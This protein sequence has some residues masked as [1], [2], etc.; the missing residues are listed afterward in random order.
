MIA[1]M[2][3]AAALSG[4][5]LLASCNSASSPDAPAGT[6]AETAMI[7]VTRPWSRETAQGQDAGGAFLSISNTGQTADRLVGGSTPVAADVQV[8]TVDMA[9]G[10]MR[11]RQ[12]ED[13]LEIPAGQTV[14][15]KPGSFHI[16]LMQLKQPLR[17]GEK[18]PLTLQFENAGSIPVELD[19]Q[20]VGTA[21]PAEAA[22][23]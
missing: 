8:H 23:D 5:A 10:V 22:G 17:R 18:V 11:M 4:T 13:G 19:V 1:R 20:P 2:F 15:L 6:E 16:M 7:A 14:T 9:G 12:L 3:L 21:G